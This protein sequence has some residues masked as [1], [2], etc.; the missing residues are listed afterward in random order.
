MDRGIGMQIKIFYLLLLCF[1]LFLHLNAHEGHE[2]KTIQGSMASS[3]LVSDPHYPDFAFRVAVKRIGNLH[4]ILI[5]FPIALIVM[6]VAAELLFWWT[7]IPLYAFSARFMINAAAVFGIPTVLFGLALSFGSNYE[8]V[9][10][11][12]FEWHRFFGLVTA[13]L[14]VLCAIMKEISVRQ[15]KGML[16]YA[17]FLFLAFISL[18]VTGYLG[19]SLT[20]GMV[21]F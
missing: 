10:R 17:I 9:S 16:E 20:F 3:E 12:I 1:N 7:R 11:D 14:A 21:G 8:G 18:S 13:T 6:T 2:H 5:H 15:K 19:G 4:F